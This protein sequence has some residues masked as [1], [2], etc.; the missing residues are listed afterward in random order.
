MAAIATITP[1]LMRLAKSIVDRPATKRS[2]HGSYHAGS[3][4]FNT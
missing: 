3:L 2:P 1:I 4:S